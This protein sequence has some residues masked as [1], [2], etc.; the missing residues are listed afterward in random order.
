VKF[1]SLLLGSQGV[2]ITTDDKSDRDPNAYLDY[3]APR[4]PLK[5]LP[6]VLYRQQL[7]NAEWPI[8]SGDVVQVSPLIS[9]IV[10]SDVPR[11]LDGPAPDLSKSFM[12][13]PFIGVEIHGDDNVDR[14]EL[15]LLDTTPRAIGAKYRYWLVR[16]D[17]LTGAPDYIVPAT[18]E[19]VTP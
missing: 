1:F 14:A 2:M 17:E 7:T 11:A 10:W 13:D 3:I 4:L 12:R 15:Y 6:A 19:E 5:T 18:L 8:V 9:R 16:F